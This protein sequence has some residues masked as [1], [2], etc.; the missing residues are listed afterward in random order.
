MKRFY[1]D[2]QVDSAP[3]GFGVLLD[4]RPVLTPG[5]NRLLLPKRLLA[6]AI[7]QE[8][9]AQGDM[10][11]PVS[12]PMLRLANSALDG[13]SQKRDEVIAEVMKFGAHD[14]LCYRAE[15]A[16]LAARQRAAWDPLLEWVK[17]RHGVT[18][19]VTT[20]ISHIG[21]T[22]EAL[23]RLR[24][25]ILA[26]DGFGLAALHVLASITGSLVLALAVSDGRIDSRTAFQ[27][28][29][30]DEEHQAERWSRDAEA[31][32]RATTLAREMD[33]AAAFLAAARD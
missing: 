16:A 26:H 27:L 6:E 12:M 23:A 29:R 18:L 30:L 33:A 24:K 4:G 3:E 9:R 15:D 5:R 7:A 25:A 22:P 28:C 13:V 19:N 17:S 8:W 10:V 2:V 20:G 32:S 31:E 11:V 1:Q 14:L 21:Q